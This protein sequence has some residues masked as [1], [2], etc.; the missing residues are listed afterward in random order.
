MSS[1]LASSLTSQDS[2]DSSLASQDSQELN[3]HE[4]KRQECIQQLLDIVDERLDPTWE[5]PSDYDSDSDS[6]DEHVPESDTF[7]DTQNDFKLLGELLN[8][9]SSNNSQ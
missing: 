9:S 5:P 6:D 2:Q 3:S 7:Y 8:G 1:S 4:L